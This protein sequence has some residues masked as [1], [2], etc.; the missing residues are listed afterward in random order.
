MLDGSDSVLHIL[1]ISTSSA[2]WFYSAGDDLISLAGAYAMLSSSD[3]VSRFL[4]DS[5]IRLEN[6][7]HII[8]GGQTSVQ[9]MT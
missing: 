1:P 7:R 6:V 8:G 2:L 5:L 9:Q 3:D 4:V